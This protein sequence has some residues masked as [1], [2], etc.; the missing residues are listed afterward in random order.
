MVVKYIVVTYIV[1]KCMVVKYV[2]VKYI[3]VKYMVVKYIVVKYIVVTYMVVKYI[4]VKSMI[5]LVFEH[6]CSIDCLMNLLHSVMKC[7]GPHASIEVDLV[8]NSEKLSSEIP[9]KVHV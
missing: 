2:V 1:V 5:A 7:T 3:V 8:S 6:I 4:V 9:A